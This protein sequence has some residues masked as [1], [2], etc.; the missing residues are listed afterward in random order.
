MKKFFTFIV[1]HKKTVIVLYLVLVVICVPLSNQVSVN[2]DIN[3]YLPSDSDSTVALSVME[4][5]FG[6]GIPNARVMIYDVTIPE[7][8]EYKEQIEAVDGVTDVTWLDDSVD[9]TMPLSSLDEET[10][11]TYYKDETALFSVTIEEESRIDA[12]D[13]IRQ[14]IGDD[15]AMTGS[16]VTTATATTGTVSEI[17]K[18][19]VIAVAFVLLVLILTTKSW[20]DPLLVLCGL[21]V[22]IMLNNGTHII[23]GEISFVTNAA[24]SILQLAVSLDYSV[25]LLHQFEDCKKHSPDAKSAMVDALC[26]SVTSIFSSGLTTLIGFAALIF[27]RFTLGADLGMALAKGVAISLVTV[28]T[29]VPCLMLA[30]DKGA[31]K[32]THRPFVPGFKKFGK[33]VH[34]LAVPMMIVFLII[35]APAYLA[36]NSN[37]YYYGASH[38]YGTDT[39]LGADTEAIEDKFGESDTWV[40]LVPEGDLATETQLSD[41]LGELE[42][43]T[44]IISYVD[45]AGAEVPTEYLDDDTLSQLMSE[46]YSRMVISVNVPYEG[47]ETFALVEEVREIAESYY[48]DEYYLAGEGVSTYDLKDVVESDMVRINLIVILAVF[49]VLILMLK[50]IILPVML[51]LC[52]EAAIWINLS[53]PYFMSEEIFYIAYLIISSIQLGATVDY[54]ILMTDHYREVRLTFD[55]RAAVG[56]TLSQVT[57]SILTSGT[58]LAVVGLLMGYVSTNRLLAQLGIFIGRGAIFSMIIVL[59]VMPGMLFVLDK[60]VTHDFGGKRRKKFEERAAKIRAAMPAPPE[61]HAPEIHKPEIHK[62]GT[63][64]TETYSTKARSTETHSTETNKPELINI[65]KEENENE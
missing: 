59:F 64:S 16:A 58:V 33:V 53:C 29:F 17:S 35:I 37:A 20:L 7:A 27:M 13:A 49:V 24:C 21:G 30:A 45:L 46:N 47:D 26:E 19:V 40:L 1:N 52:I 63:N 22:A 50:S 11:E 36:S 62:P 23:F 2:Y 42:H 57:V 61:I 48:G 15:N 32:L 56:E 6:G 34:R 31:Q 41:E 25:F 51:V 9:I 43:V 3:D 38:I 54:A 14:I 10:V 39:Q 28:F 18:I 12:V 44:D 4:D 65:D 8:L 55:K 60:Q 5:E